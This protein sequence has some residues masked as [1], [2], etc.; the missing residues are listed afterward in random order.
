MNSAAR[1][2]DT[3]L[4]DSRQC[5]PVMAGLG[6]LYVPTYLALY[7]VF[8]SSRDG[9]Y[10]AVMLVIVGWLFWRERRSLR[11]AVQ[12][13]YRVPGAII[14]AVGLLCYVV[15]RSQSF[16]QL[17]AASQI[18]VLFGLA[19]L[20]MK[21]CDIRRIAFPI[22]LLAFVIP[23]PGSVADELLLPLKELVSRIVDNTLFAAGY[24]IARNGVVLMIGSYSLLIAD[25]CSG[26]NSMIAL[27]GIGLLYIHLAK[28]NSGARTV[29]LLASV[30]P[31]ALLANVI[32]VLALVLITYYAGDGAG[33]AF[34]DE[35]AYLEIVFAFGAFF[36][37]DSLLSCA[38]GNA[39]PPVARLDRGAT[40]T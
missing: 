36:A 2:R 21:L 29:V 7:R 18:P 37:L 9:S 12:P 24:P 20:F 27:S 4:S 14:L 16:Y 5:I 13:P 22:L 8:W 28:N 6:A 40:R 31:I 11:M 32:R 38:H 35:A 34:H 33:T 39:P 1:L 23:V 10:G 19:F 17:E 3:P 25:A 15:G 30:L 26:L